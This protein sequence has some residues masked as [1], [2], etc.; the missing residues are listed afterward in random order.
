[1]QNTFEKVLA[2]MPLLL[3]IALG[4]DR[5][6]TQPAAENK[7]GI[8]NGYPVVHTH[9]GTHYGDFGAIT[10]PA[11]GADFYGQDADFLQKQ[12]DYTD[13]G[14]GTVT[15]NVTKLMWQRDMGDKMTLEEAEAKLAVLNRSKYNDW[16][17]PTIKELYSLADYTGCVFGDRA[18]KSFIDTAYFRQPVGN[19]AAGERE[20]DAQTWSTTDY[21]GVTMRNDRSRFG[22]NFVDGRIKAYPL[23]N[24]F[25]QQPN[26]LYFRFVRGNKYYGLNKFTD[27]K[28]S[29]VTDV[30]TGLMW[31]Q[32][33]SGRGMD[34]KTALRYAQNL[35]LAGHTDWR[36]PT[37]KELQSIVDYSVFVQRDGKAAINPVFATTAVKDPAGNANFPY[38]W[39]A[40]TLLDGP[41]PG[42]QAAYVC[43]GR[44]TASM[45][46][47]IVDAHG[48][49]AVR[50]DPKAGARQ[51]YPKYFGPQGDAQYVYNYVRCV[52][53]K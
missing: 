2:L 38:F 32:H 33:D 21:N 48:A 26:R 41:A 7:E 51:D 43:F 27:N 16:R 12:P 31:Q 42:D 10:Q 1:M 35:T 44:A 22:F 19:T 49:G 9:V 4:C 17:I 6:R 25:T 53:N 23:V 20:I 15:D 46:G 14:D 13:N 45:N 8:E 39:S 50:S 37:V 52:R 36:L 29:T 11:V 30:A 5:N 3:L 28:D 40:T 34:W 47:T 24:P 18:V